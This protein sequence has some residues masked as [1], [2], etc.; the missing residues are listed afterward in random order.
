[1]AARVLVTAAGSGSSNNLVRSL[2]AGDPSLEISA[3]GSCCSRTLGRACCSPHR[4]VHGQGN[5]DSLPGRWTTSIGL[6][7]HR[8]FA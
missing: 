8:R 7:I 2:T 5:P 3:A 1:M 4:E 6:A